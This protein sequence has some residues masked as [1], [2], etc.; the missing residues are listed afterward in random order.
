MYIYIY[1]YIYIRHM[2]IAAKSWNIRLSHSEYNYQWIKTSCAFPYVEISLR[3]IW[4]LMVT[5]CSAERLFSQWKHI[6]NPYIT[7]LKEEELDSLSL[8]RI[9][10]DLLRRVNFVEIIKE[11]F[12]HSSTRKNFKM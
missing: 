1:I 7:T 4:A 10:A 11:F 9:E 6:K 3:I 12:R 2:L 5:I 8:L